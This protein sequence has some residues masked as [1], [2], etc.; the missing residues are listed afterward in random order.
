VARGDH[1]ALQA[2]IK[3]YG[4]LVWSIARRL[5]PTTADAED[6]VQEV[7]TQLWRT[8]SSY[9]ASRGPEGAF[10]AL[11]AR[12]RVIDRLRKHQT[13]SQMEI[14]ADS[15]TLAALSA[16]ESPAEQQSDAARAA[17]V[18]ASLPAEQ[19]KAI[20]MSMHGWSH[21]EIAEHTALPLGTVKTLVRRGLLRIREALGIS[22][23]EGA[24][25]EAAG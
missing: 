10:V 8:A 3:R 25:G 22:V 19:R 6:A 5:S 14:A 16:V 21:G 23:D 11:L 15:E 24:S 1:D 2:C 17:Q 18:L 9:E 20:L 7:F 13:W 4:A 12:R